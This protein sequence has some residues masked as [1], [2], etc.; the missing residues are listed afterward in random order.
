M[1]GL[2]DISVSYDDG[3]LTCSFLRLRAGD[4]NQRYPLDQTYTVFWAEGSGNPGRAI[5]AKVLLHPTW[6]CI[7]WHSMTQHDTLFQATQ[8]GPPWLRCCC[9]PHDIVSHDTAWHTVLGNPGRATMANVLLYPTWQC[10]MAHDTVFVKTWLM[11][12]HYG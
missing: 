12:C 5:M 4:G 7:A 11:C 6:H 2:S 3:V 10:R 8:V 1:Q 9:T